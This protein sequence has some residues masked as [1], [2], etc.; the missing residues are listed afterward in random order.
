[1]NLGGPDLVSAG[2]RDIFVA[3][4]DPAGNH[5]W[6]ANYGDAMDQFTSTFE[7]N[8]WLTLAFGP[9]GEIHVAGS[10]FGTL[11]FGSASLTAS[12]TN[13]DVFHVMLDPDGSFLAGNRYGGSNTDFA[14]DVVVAGPAHAVMVG[15]SYGTE[16]DFGDAGRISNHGNG[17]GFTVKFAVP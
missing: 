10:L 5:V 1:M 6:S 2:E 4:L 15:R 16:I 12:G 9:S 3:K 7:V 8:S 17:D 11:D 14:L 13:S